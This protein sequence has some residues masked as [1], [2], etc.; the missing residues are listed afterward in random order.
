MNKLSLLPDWVINDA[1]A[2]DCLASGTLMTLLM[3][4]LSPN[5]DWDVAMTLLIINSLMSVT[6][7]WGCSNLTRTLAGVQKA[8][9]KD[10]AVKVNQSAWL[11]WIELGPV[12]HTHV[13]KS[14]VQE[15]L[16]AELKQRARKDHQAT[17]WSQVNFS[18]E[19]HG[20][21]KWCWCR[22]CPLLLS[23][24]LRVG[25]ALSAALGN[26][27]CVFAFFF[28]SSWNVCEFRSLSGV[29]AA[30]TLWSWFRCTSEGHLIWF[31]L[32]SGKLWWK[33]VLMG[34]HHPPPPPPPFLLLSVLR[35]LI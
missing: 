25:L 13:K 34:D 24:Q 4:K 1:V 32:C 14:C 6:E 9:W 30:C 27:C 8:F 5:C 26:C 33:T 19:L 23:I 16:T 31:R 35:L 3:T 29:K 12:C 15:W 2:A 10:S 7:E 18:L 22:I 20:S 21:G 11:D 17:Y 28:L